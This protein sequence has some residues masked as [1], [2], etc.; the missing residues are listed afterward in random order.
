MVTKHKIGLV[1]MVIKH[2]IGLVTMVTKHKIGLVAMVT[3]HI[4]TMPGYCVTMA[5]YC[6]CL[7][8]SSVTVS[9]H[10]IVS[11]PSVLK[12]ER[13]CFCQSVQLPLVHMFALQK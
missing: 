6:S 3:K 8:Y 11:L 13:S 9:K 12:D 1:T 4:F 2:K 5:T 10:Y 7:F